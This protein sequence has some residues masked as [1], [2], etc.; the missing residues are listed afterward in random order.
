MNV[1]YVFRDPGA[2][3]A[4]KIGY[5]SDSKQYPWPFRYRQ[6]QSHSPRQIEVAAA[7]NIAGD[8]SALRRLETAAKNHFSPQRRTACDV[9]E[10]FDVAPD[11]GIAELGRKFCL[12]PPFVR[13][14]VLNLSLW[15]GLPYDDWRERRHLYKGQTWQRLI[16]IFAEDAAERRLK[17]IHTVSYDTVYRY[18]F[19][20]NPHRVFLIA[21][22]QFPTSALGPGPH[23]ALGNRKVEAAWNELVADPRFCGAPL[24]SQ[25]GWLNSGVTL[26]DVDRLLRFRGLEHFD[27]TQPKPSCMRPRDSQIEPIAHGA[28]PPLGR[29]QIEAP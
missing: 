12:G 13:H 23:L 5:N 8:R 29:V 18:A 11:E 19:T 15:D 27:L 1:L 20:Y 7:W 25:V 17:A 2:P 22:Y 24:S 14:A 3:N 6:A 4:F 28:P 10:W 16:W 26:S 9:N 21:A